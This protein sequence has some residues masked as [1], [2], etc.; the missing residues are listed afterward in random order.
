MAVPYTFGTATA[1]IPLSQLD[2]NFST[3]ITLGNTAIQL[4]NT[5]TTL[6]NMTLANATISSGNVTL[7]NVTVTT[8][9]VTTGNITTLAVGSGGIKSAGNVVV[10][11][12]DFTNTSVT[13]AMAVNGYGIY[14]YVTSNA[15]NTT[16]YSGINWY[17]PTAFSGNNGAS[18]QTLYGASFVA[19]VKNDGSG[20]TNLANAY[21]IHTN[22]SVDSSAVNA[23]VRAQGFV[24]SAQRYSATDLSTRTDNIVY[25]VQSSVSN[26]ITAPSTIVSGNLQAFIGSAS[27]RS[28]TA[29]LHVGVGSTLGVGDTST[30][31]V[32]SS[33]SAFQFYGSGF[34]VGAASG[35]AATVTTGSSF[36][37]GGPTVA[38]TGTMTTY[39]G[40][41]LGAASVTGTL[42]NNYG[43]Y[44]ADT[45]A[46]NYFGGNVGIGTTAPAQKLDVIGGK[47]GFG[48]TINS[49]K[50]YLYSTVY[51]FG[52]DTGDLVSFTNTTAGFSWKQG[53]YGG[54]TYMRLDGS[55]NLGIGTSSPNASAI[56]DA[57]STTKGVR[58]PNMTTT[59]KNAISSPAAGLM[60]FD[61]TL[62]KLCVYSGAAWQTI[63]SV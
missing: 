10:G 31:L 50:I 14:P 60:V 7:T 35:N 18:T 45:A 56:L 54:T 61:T 13:G 34:T 53:N 51:G 52:I 40:L 26:S 41:Y 20:G 37:A 21:G 49:D 46:I 27:N 23:R 28:G 9:N 36:Y 3:T 43:V 2:T 29:T 62:A 25:G 59:Q 16:V 22:S 44:S 1:A 38:A 4:G 33:P 32:T 11:T 47:I 42:T 58:M 30:S 8:A 39:Y 24:S 55:G 48:S 12:V 15:T 5:V 57:Q 19:N 6:N 63:T 17:T